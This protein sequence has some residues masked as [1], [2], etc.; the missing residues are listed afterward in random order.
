MPEAGGDNE[1]ANRAVF[2]ASLAYW[3]AHR[4]LPRAPPAE[5]WQAAAEFMRRI[6]LVDKLVPAE[7]CLRMSS[8]EGDERTSDWLMV[9]G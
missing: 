2:D 3:T 5:D 6:G 9:N 7:R 1:P 4:Y 8:L